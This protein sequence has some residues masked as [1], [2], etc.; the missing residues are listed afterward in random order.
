MSNHGTL[1]FV[2][3]TSPTAQRKF[4]V[5]EKWSYETAR[6]EFATKHTFAWNNSSKFFVCQFPTWLPVLF[7]APA[8]VIPWMRWRHSDLAIPIFL[9]LQVAAIGL[10]VYATRK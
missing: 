8:A 10:I 9:T 7:L 4:K 3:R 1:A 6:P 5:P 2:R